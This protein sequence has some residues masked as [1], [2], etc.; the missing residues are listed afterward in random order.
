LHAAGSAA[1]P[2]RHLGATIVPIDLDHLGNAT[3]AGIDLNQLEDAFRSGVRTFH[4]S[5]PSN[6]VGVIY[7]AEEI[8]AI[9]S[10]ADERCGSHRR[11]ALLAA[12]VR[13]PVVPSPP[14]GTRAGDRRGSGRNLF[15][16]LP[17]L[18]VPLHTF[19]RALRQQAGVTVTP[20]SEFSPDDSDRIHLNFSQNHAAAVKAV[21]R[22]AAM[23]ERYRVS[24]R[25]AHEPR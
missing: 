14:S 23:V 7:S 12:V 2:P 4:F 11:P 10:L 3:R 15:P 17:K 9:A 6:P 18:D 20:G 13:G 22:V 24:P 21:H 1:D 5:N 25:A 16:R 8:A 19:V